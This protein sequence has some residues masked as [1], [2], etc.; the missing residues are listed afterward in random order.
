[1]LDTLFSVLS[2]V[3]EQVRT[4]TASSADGLFP[5]YLP[6]GSASAKKDSD[7]CSTTALCLFGEGLAVIPE[8]QVRSMS[9]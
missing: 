3:R 1:M 2:K 8:L 6:T 4:S 5:F 9:S 7:R